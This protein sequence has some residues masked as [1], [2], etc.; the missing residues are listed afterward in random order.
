M[1]LSDRLCFWVH[2]Q[3]S[4]L[5]LAFSVRYNDKSW[6]WVLGAAKVAS[7]L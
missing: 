4:K 3:Q 7:A 6:G 5:G 2:W 1:G